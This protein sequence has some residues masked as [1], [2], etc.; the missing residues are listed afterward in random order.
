[1]RI[2][3]VIP[4][5]NEADCVQPLLSEIRAAL[6]GVVDYEL[7]FVDDGS[8]DGTF[9][10]LMTAK[11]QGFSR[12]RICRHPVSC[13][14]STAI[15]TGV[16]AA[17][18]EWIVTLDGDGQND[19]ADILRLLEPLQDSDHDPQL[20]LVTGYRIRRQDS[21]I[22]R[23]SSRIANTIRDRLLKDGTPDSG[24][25]LKVFPR[26]VFLELPYFDHMHRFLPTLFRRHGGVVKT[27]EVN[28]RPR[29]HGHSKYGLFDRLWVGV[30]DL[31]GVMWLQRRSK[32]PRF[33]E[34]F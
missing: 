16:R 29:Q 15:L 28:H 21:W 14:Q 23:I 6:D 30:V 7:I 3:L 13:G 31:F 4:V 34:E 20:Q 10:K 2:S 19:P 27:I 8:I 24:C 12:L 22:R 5:Y 1:M 32:R 33:V 18:T 26:D 17:K 9:N 11:Q 25:G